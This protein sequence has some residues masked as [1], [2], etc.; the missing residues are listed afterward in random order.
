MIYDLKP[1][2]GNVVPLTFGDH[3]QF[4][5]RDIERINEAFDKMPSPKIIITTEKT[6]RDWPEWTDFLKR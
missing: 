1:Y 5:G 2:A 6:T 4:T 3:H